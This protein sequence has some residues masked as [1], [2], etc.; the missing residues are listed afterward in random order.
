MMKK[1]IAINGSPRKNWNTQTLL[2]QALKGAEDAGAQTEMLDLYKLDFKGCI[3]CFGCK[4]AGVL[5]ETCIVKDELMPI[6]KRI[7][8]ADGLIL[9]SPIYFSNVP[10][11]MRSFLERFIFPYYSY[12]KQPS[13]FPKPIPTAFIYTMNAPKFALGLIGYR[14]LFSSHRKLLTHVTHKESQILTST[15]TR[16]FNDYSK[17]AASRFNAARHN[18]RHEKVFPKDCAKAYQMGWEMGQ[19]L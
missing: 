12:D 18:E 7:T 14:K 17:Y 19:T 9:G 13:Q 15:E 6:L 8:E 2:Q 4:R 3:S 10:G 1:I 5:V 11:E 16:Q